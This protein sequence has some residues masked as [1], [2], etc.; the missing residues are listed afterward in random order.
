MESSTFSI[1]AT[2]SQVETGFFLERIEE[3]ARTLSRVEKIE[4]L[5]RAKEYAEG[6]DSVRFAT[7]GK[8]CLTERE[9]E[10]LVLV[11]HGYNRRSIGKCLDISFNTAARHISNIYSK[12][13][14]STAAEATRW[15]C[16]HQL[17]SI[18]TGTR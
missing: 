9:K 8:Y 7:S 14:V 12:L 6:V 16:A 2:G 15:A 10:V 18:D 4:L 13:G 5:V 11:A 3:I 17:I 1:S